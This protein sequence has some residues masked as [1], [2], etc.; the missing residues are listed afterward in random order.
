[1]KLQDFN[2]LKKKLPSPLILLLISE[3]SERAFY[4]KALL[5][6]FQDNTIFFSPDNFSPERFLQEADSLALFAKQTLVHI[7]DVD[8]LK[9]S[10]VKV[11]V[12]YAKRPNPSVILILSA[13][14]LSANSALYRT[15]E[16]NGLLFQP[17]E[18]KPWEKEK[19]L[20]GW[21]SQEAARHGKRLGSE[22]AQKLL[23]SLGS[24][25][26]FLVNELEKL[27]CF[28]GN[29]EEISPQDIAQLVAPLSQETLWQLGEA[30]FARKTL[31]AIRIGNE[32][33][34]GGV[35]LF[36]LLGHLRSQVHQG[37]KLLVLGGEPPP[38]L[39]GKFLEDI[40]WRR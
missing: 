10:D 39:K 5:H 16:Q 32:L 21:L 36:A 17:A 7:D 30:V 6:E 1:M 23:R 2:L 24:D 28:V 19:R 27:I 34:R 12:E 18:E 4:E 33:L 25:R 15:V 40:I 11:L 38:Y 31:D 22:G 9:A 13:S 3:E 29:K 35:S 14:R 37:L 20:S 8:E 26:F